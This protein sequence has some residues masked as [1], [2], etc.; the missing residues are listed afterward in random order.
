MRMTKLLAC[1]ILL[2]ALP[3][4]A[5]ELG[6]VGDCANGT[7]TYYFSGG[8][9]YEGEWKDGAQTGQGTYYFANG[10]RYEGEFK[11]GYFDGRGTLYY[12][13]GDRYEGEWK[14]H[15][16]RGQG[17]WYFADGDHYKGE[18][19]DGERTKVEVC[20][21]SVCFA[22]VPWIYD[23]IAF[24]PVTVGFVAAVLV[25][26]GVQRRYESKLSEALRSVALSLGMSF[27]DRRNIDAT[28]DPEKLPFSR[29]L[30]KAIFWGGVTALA[31]FL[32]F[33]F[34]DRGVLHE[35]WTALSISAFIWVIATVT[36]LL[37]SNFFWYGGGDWGNGGGGNGGG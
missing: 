9:R 27:E 31:S 7:G 28:N 1:V 29:R 23:V 25:I 30:L 18:W 37:P 6:C 26:W 13:N 36:Y 2:T 8:G 14:Y 35:D 22:V 32:F 34:D 16:Q 21:L 19:V 15:K 5:A 12:A 33:S 17:T 4:Y 10:D 20:V 11:V 24:A 3:V